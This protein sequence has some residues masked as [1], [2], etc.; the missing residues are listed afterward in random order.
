MSDELVNDFGG[1][2]TRRPSDK[3]IE[4]LKAK[5]TKPIEDV[6]IPEDDDGLEK[7]E[8]AW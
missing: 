7:P 8:V 2:A 3:A 4:A 5:K 6:E 1:N